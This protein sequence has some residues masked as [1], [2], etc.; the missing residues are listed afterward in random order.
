MLLLDGLTAQGVAAQAGAGLTIS[1]TRLIFPSASREAS[2]QV[3]NENTYPVMV[4]AWVDA[5]DIAADPATIDAPFVILPPLIRLQPNEARA[6]RVVYSQQSLPL[7]R[8]SIFWFNAQMIPPQVDHR[9]SNVLDVSVRIRQKIF[10]RPQQLVRG[11]AEWIENLDCR[12]SRQSDVVIVRCRNPTPYFATVDR[13]G[14]VQ[15]DGLFSAPGDMLA[16]FGDMEF[17]LAKERAANNPD[18][19]A[20]APTSKLSIAVI[21]DEGYV[22]TLTKDLP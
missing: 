14:V 8:E 7:D 1:A 3:Y 5:G 10:F 20:L 16:P 2:L 6:L 19:S 17:R 18:R 4:Q 15:E 13:L 22:V 21:G 12:P 9:S 11:S